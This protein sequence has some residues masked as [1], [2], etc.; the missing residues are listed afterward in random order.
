M[1]LTRN[2]ARSVERRDWTLA[3]PPDWAF[4][5][6]GTSRSKSGQIVTPKKALGLIPVFSAVRIVA[7][8]V[9]SLPVNVIRGNGRATEPAPD[10]WQHQ[11]LHERPNS[12]HAPDVFF[13]LIGGHLTGWGNAYVEKVK[14]GRDGRQ[15]VGELWPLPPGNVKVSRDKQ[16]RKRFEVVGNPTSFG[17]DTILH[18]QSFGYD[19]LIGLSP[20]GQAREGL[21]VGLARQEWQGAF[22]ANS[23][24]PPG[25]IKLKR[26]VSPEAADRLAAHWKRLHAGPSK[27]GEVAVLDED[28][29]YQ[30]TA[31]SPRDAQFIQAMQ[32]DATQVAVLFDVPAHWIGGSIG[33]SLTYSTVEGEALHWVTFKLRPRL[34]RVERAFRHDQDVFPDAGD[35]LRPK[36]NADALLRGDSEAR[37]NFYEK[38]SGVG[39]FSANDVRA[40]EDLPPIPGGDQYQRPQAPP[41]PNTES[42][43]DEEGSP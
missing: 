15:V 36:F 29:E 26:K 5:A 16:G 7:T 4:E 20:I 25:V 24:Q 1:G 34:V 27:S 30:S 22:Y 35:F 23:A 6:L 41:A 8:G 31:I 2:I 3:D 12:E 38:M 9:G 14:A 13:E 18:V 10:S 19:G 17:T 11:L 33:D 39:A 21:G 40:E 43:D 28:A 32:F 42:G 37:A